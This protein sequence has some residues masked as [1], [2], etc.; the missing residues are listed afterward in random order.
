MEVSIPVST[1][2]ITIP[3][4]FQA[5][6]TLVTTR[7][8]PS[9]VVE[10]LSIP[11]VMGDTLLHGFSQ[12]TCMGLKSL[13]GYRWA[14]VAFT[15]LDASKKPPKSRSLMSKVLGSKVFNVSSP[16]D[17]FPVTAAIS[18]ECCQLLSS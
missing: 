2:V 16:V 4:L 11:K 17:L 1:Q 18:H 12:S 10:S 15:T 8:I 14:F 9:A 3:G 13:A 5:A 6:D 7:D